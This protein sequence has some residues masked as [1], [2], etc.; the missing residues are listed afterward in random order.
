MSLDKTV[1]ADKKP[2]KTTGSVKNK[3]LGCL[4]LALII[5]GAGTLLIMAAI[6]LPKINLENV[7]PFKFSASGDFKIV[8][9]FGSGSASKENDDK[10]ESDPLLFDDR[11]NTDYISMMSAHDAFKQAIASF[12]ADEIDETKLKEVCEE[13]SAYFQ[14]MANALEYGTNDQQNEYL[15]AFKAAA[16]S[17]QIAADAVLQYIGN[18]ALSSLE[19]GSSDVRRNLADAEQAYTAINSRR[20]SYLEGAGVSAAEIDMRIG[21]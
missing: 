6:Y 18:G 12:R 7:G 3:T 11:A 13:T 21:N 15:R 17:D 8:W 10:P 19:D 20:V 2:R 1:K 9:P 16:M 14:T 5:F 4:P